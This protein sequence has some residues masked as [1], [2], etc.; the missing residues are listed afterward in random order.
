MA[1]QRVFRE[2]VENYSAKALPTGQ[3]KLLFRL[4]QLK[5]F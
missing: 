3:L 5:L 2:K 4:T 1:I